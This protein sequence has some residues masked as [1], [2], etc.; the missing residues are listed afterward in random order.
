MI[1]NNKVAYGN[2]YTNPIVVC[3]YLLGNSLYRAEVD[4]DLPSNDSRN[5]PRSIA[6]NV[7]DFNVTDTIIK[8]SLSTQ[9]FVT[10]SATFAPKY[11]RS[12]WTAALKS[13]TA[14]RQGTTVGTKVQLRNL[15]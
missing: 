14:A 12:N 4:P 5:N 7:S 10:V 9:T 13:N 1:V 6:D 15:F 3:Y 2:N 8:T 11:S